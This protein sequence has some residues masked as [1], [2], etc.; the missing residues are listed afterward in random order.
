MEVA[1]SMRV[2]VINSIDYTVFVQGLRLNGEL[3][4]FVHCDVRKWDPTVAKRLLS[5]WKLFTDLFNGPLF[6]L[7]EKGDE[8]H[9]KFLALFG[10][11]FIEECVGTDSVTRNLF[12]H[13]NKNKDIT[14]GD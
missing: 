12:V 9:R 7:N 1:Q 11:E 3:L 4:V 10:F 14:D 2:P 8:K 13:K 6:A 5:D